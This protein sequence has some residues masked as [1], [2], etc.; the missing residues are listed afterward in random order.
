MPKKIGD[1]GMRFTYDLD[2]MQTTAH[3][4]KG[5][6]KEQETLA[7]HTF[8]FADY[9]ENI[10]PRVSLYGQKGILTDRTSD[11]KDKLAKLEEMVSYHDF[12]SEGNW[13]KEVVAGVRAV[14]VEI[15]ALARYKKVAIPAV[16][17]SLK[18]YDDKQRET[19]LQNPKLDVFK[20]L[21][22]KERED[23]VE[24]GMDDLL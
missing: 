1:V 12:L 7:K 3:V 24:V 10:Q 8:D 22:R 23:A 11:E 19:V 9:P 13:K 17:K 18:K 16:Q 4:V 5:T 20:T 21:I 2:A 14:S 15:E 6:G